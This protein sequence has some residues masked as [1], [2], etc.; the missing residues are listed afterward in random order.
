MRCPRNLAQLQPSYLGATVQGNGATLAPHP[1]AS[2]TVTHYTDAQLSDFPWI[3]STDTLRAD[4]LAAAYLSALDRIGGTLDALGEHHR[5]ELAQLA[6]HANDTMGPEV[7]DCQQ[8]AM[9][10]AET[11]L[12][13]LAPT[14]FYFGGHEGDGACFG[15]WITDEWAECLKR[16]NLGNDDP[17]GWASLIRELDLG[18]VDPENFE[19]AYQGQAEGITEELAGADYAQQLADDTGTVDFGSLPWPLTCIDWDQAWRE[20]RMGDGYWLQ[21]LGGGDWLVFRNV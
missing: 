13:E 17:T 16:L 14:G 10:A 2:Q 4:H 5:A 11:L 1:I 8:F 7:S 3:V 6:S 18:G 20:L 15:F 19:D 9:E 21:E 12:G